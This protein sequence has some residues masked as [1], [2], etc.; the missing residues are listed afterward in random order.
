M[1]NVSWLMKGK[2]IKSCNCDFGCPCDFLGAPTH[3]A[4]RGLIAMKIDEGH[5]GEVKL[6]GLHW[7]AIVEFPGPL[8]EGNGTLQPVIDAR[9]SEAQRNALLAILSGKEQAPTTMFSIF[10]SLMTKIHDPVFAPFAYEHDYG[11]R[12]AKVSIPGVVD[13]CI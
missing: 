10:G 7:A 4:C 9:A 11:A 12:T 13:P 1:A 6:D 3:H 5:F 8:H 2:H